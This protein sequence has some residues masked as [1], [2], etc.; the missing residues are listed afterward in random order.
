MFDSDKSRR[1]ERER[2]RERGDWTERMKMIETPASKKLERR[3]QCRERTAF[4]LHLSSLTLTDFMERANTEVVG[5]YN[6]Y[7][8]NTEVVGY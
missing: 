5:Y 4:L 2:E 6:G 3:R 1:R 8:S 7:K